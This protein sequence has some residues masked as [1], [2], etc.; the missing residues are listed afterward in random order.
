MTNAG[1]TSGGAPGAPRQ[2]RTETSNWRLT[3]LVAKRDYLRAVR[4]RGYIFGTLLLPVGIATLMAISA[5][6]SMEGSQGTTTGAIVIVNESDVPLAEDPD[7]P[8]RVTLLSAEEA[9]RQ[10]DAG[11]VGGYYVVP[12]DLASSG[13]VQHVQATGGLG[14]EQLATVETQGDL[15]GYLVR[16]ALLRQANVDPA[17]ATRIL[18]GVTVTTVTTAGDVV[19]GLDIA[20]GIGAPIIFVGLFI[21]SIF[22]TSGYLLQSVTEEKENRVV[23]I[24]LSSVPSMPLMAGKIL[25]L[26]AAGLTQVGIWI[27]TAL[28]AVPLLSSQLPDFAGIDVDPTLLVL[29]PVYFVLGYLTYGAIFAAIGALAPGNRE[30]SQYSGFLGIFAAIP[31]ILISVF[32]TDPDSLIVLALALFP[33]TSPTA[34]LLILGMSETTPWYLVAASLLSLT[35]FTALATWTSARIFRAT[36]LLYGVRPSLTQ[37]MDAVRTAR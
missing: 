4:R 37:L 36:V 1:E 17:L 12:A 32:I 27:A 5:I 18:E 13:E 11:E 15:I 31:F 8:I 3:R 35:I 9:R 30:A 28:V 29:A 33:L 19:S 25:G 26:G 2:G 14:L 7:G 21:A 34:M 16:D 20:A 23:E 6:F 24:V 22:I 10:L